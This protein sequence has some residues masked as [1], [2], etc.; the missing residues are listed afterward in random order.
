LLSW[1]LFIAS[2]LGPFSGQAV[3]FQFAAPEG[4]DYAVNRYGP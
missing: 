4:L 2:G 3:H 1:I